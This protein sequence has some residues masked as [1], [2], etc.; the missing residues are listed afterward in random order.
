METFDRTCI[1]TYSI[2]AETN[3]ERGGGVVLKDSTDIDTIALIWTTNAVRERT[4]R[5]RTLIDMSLHFVVV[6]FHIHSEA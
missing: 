6:L 4:S 1:L 3:R 5:F 2:V